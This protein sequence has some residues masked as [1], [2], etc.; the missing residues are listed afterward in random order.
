[1]GDLFQNLVLSIPGYT[2]SVNYNNDGRP[3]F[4]HS[5]QCETITGYNPEEYQS[6][7]DLWSKMIHEADRAYTLRFFKDVAK[8]KKRKPIEHRIVTKDGSIKWVMNDHVV[9]T[10][11]NGKV[12]G[13]SGVIVDITERIIAERKLADPNKELELLYK[14]SAEAENRYKLL[15]ENAS[16][17]IFVIPLDKDGVPGKF[18]EVNETACRRLGYTREELKNLSIT[19]INKPDVEVIKNLPATMKKLLADEDILTESVHIAKDGSETPVEVHSHLFR[20]NGDS[21][22]LSIVRDITERKRVEEE[23][24]KA[25]KQAEEATK[26]KDKFVSLVAHDLK[27]PLATMIGF[28]DFIK[29][30]YAPVDEAGRKLIIDRAIGTGR[31][32]ADLID[33]VLS[34]SR[35]KTG[36]VK[37]DLKFFDANYI[38]MKV[39]AYDSH[40][41]QQ[42]KIELKNDIPLNT[43]IYGDR[44][45][46]TEVLQ[47]LVVNAIKFCKENDSISI[48]M[49]GKSTICVRDNG[50]GIEPK[51]LE[52]LFN[53]KVTEVG[54]AGEKGTGYGLMLVKEIV[55]MH[56]GKLAVRSEV[57]KGCLFGVEL[58]YVRPKVLFVDDDAVFRITQREQLKEL[59]L[60][61]LEAINGRDALEIISKECPHLVISDIGMPVMGGLELLEKIR[62]IPKTKSIP[63]I[64][65]SATHGME[66]RDTVFRLGASDFVTRP[67]NTDDFIPR[68]R[69]FIG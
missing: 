30:D 25:K 7:P 27:S 2:Y 65:V 12:V 47:N 44:T 9:E 57:G 50:Q 54:S 69:R 19:D 29:K 61:I 41:A 60:E 48:H 45:L 68:V 28:L 51:L 37:L 33:D 13:E 35:M 26:L 3:T 1:M 63:V 56:G 62:A 16:D 10:D 59:D 67:I 17:A 58:P 6:D 36:T 31:Q 11:E 52:K 22:I 64:M 15:F 53:N 40:S 5:P 43:R 14:A 21:H 4:Y 18:L 46:L 38:G 24:L 34:L 8:N 32:M 23:L 20:L 66:I 42:K 55:E 49:D 39:I